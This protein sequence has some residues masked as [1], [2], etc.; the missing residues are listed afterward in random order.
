MLSVSSALPMCSVLLN[1]STPAGALVTASRALLTVGRSLP[2][3]DQPT[4]K[5]STEAPM[6]GKPTRQ[7]G[8]K[9]KPAA[10]VETSDSIAEQTALF[11][12]SGRKID[13]IESGISGTPMSAPKTW[14]R[15][16]GNG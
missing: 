2:H 3:I 8:T 5:D 12:K 4:M 11:L 15:P 6:A 10:A 16:R 9:K 13:V 7:S 1:R 14:S